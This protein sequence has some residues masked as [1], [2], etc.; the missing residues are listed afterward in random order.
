MDIVFQLLRL[1]RVDFKVQQK[2]MPA[3]QNSSI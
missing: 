1:S 2:C 3:A